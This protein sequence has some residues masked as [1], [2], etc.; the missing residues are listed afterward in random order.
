MILEDFYRGR[1]RTYSIVAPT[2]RADREG[3]KVMT[4]S[5]ALRTR[6]YKGKPQAL[7]VGDENANSI[8]TVSKDSMVL[9]DEQNKIVR[10]DG[11]AGTVMTDGSSPKHNNRVVDL[12]EKEV[13]I[14]KLTPKECWRLM[15]FDD[16]D[17]EAAA[18]VCSNSQLYKQAGNSIVVNVL[19]EILNP[20]L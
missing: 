5:C 19:C 3:L 9:Y 18:E 1:V 16:A 2:L 4:K 13:R 11:V 14:R 12:E 20:L 6:N 7:E 17:F 10:E 8:T 15:D